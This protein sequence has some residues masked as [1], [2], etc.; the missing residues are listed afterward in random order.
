MD[1][2]ER[3]ADT[4]ESRVD[5]RDVGA[6]TY[7]RRRRRR[8]KRIATCAAMLA[9][10][11]SWWVARG[12]DDSVAAP[13]A[14]QTTVGYQGYRDPAAGFAL[15]Y[16]PGWRSEAIPGGVLFRVGGQDAVSVKRTTLAKPVD[17][18]N[19]ADLR[20]V[21]DAVL[22]APEV[23]LEVLEATPTTLAGLPAVQ[24]LYT[25]DAGG[26]R[27]VHTHWFAFS[28]TSMY[29]LVFQAVPDSRLSV[30]A[31]VFDAVVASFR[32]TVPTR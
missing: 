28:G 15:E 19:V 32:T 8:R 18:S 9:F 27:G 22:G 3:R 13:V 1:T 14:S 7:A 2:S 26:V 25:F 20:A 30:L 4:W 16:P 10:A 6:G 23:G 31:P 12:V 29:T 11:G 21:T 17:A 5:A 24:Y